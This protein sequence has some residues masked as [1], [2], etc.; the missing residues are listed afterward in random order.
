MALIPALDGARL[1]ALA[2]RSPATAG[3]GYV[4][5]EFSPMHATT[6]A[7]LTGGVC[8]CGAQALFEG[9]VLSGT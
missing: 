8:S 7:C 9:L 4:Q 5:V 2:A 3:G 1:H 6:C